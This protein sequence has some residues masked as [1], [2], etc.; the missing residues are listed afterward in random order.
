MSGDE[1]L[2]CELGDKRHTKLT[3]NG[4]SGAFSKKIMVLTDFGK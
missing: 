2:Q 1:D 3:L 4:G